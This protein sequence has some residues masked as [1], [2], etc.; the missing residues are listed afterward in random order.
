MYLCPI[1]LHVMAGC[2]RAGM[3]TKPQPCSSKVI[4]IWSTHIHWAS[5]MCSACTV[6]VTGI[7]TKRYKSLLSNYWCGMCSQGANWRCPKTPFICQRLFALNNKYSHK[8]LYQVILRVKY[9][10]FFN[11]RNIQ[12]MFLKSLNIWENWN[13]YTACF[14]VYTF[15]TNLKWFC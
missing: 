11:S 4:S 8:C 12:Q 10:I 3:P 2:I 1:H 5:T 14:S 9:K 6:S 15:K 13:I 7:E